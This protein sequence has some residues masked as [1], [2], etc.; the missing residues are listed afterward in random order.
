MKYF[1]NNP[2][3]VFILLFL[4]F[5]F[6]NYGQNEVLAFPTAKG[7]G[8]YATGGRGGIVVHVTNLNDAGPGSLR[9]ALNMT[10][11]RII[12]FDVSGVITIDALLYIDADNSNFTLAGQT[13]PEGGI[14][15]DGG[16]VYFRDVDNYI[17]RYVRFKGG[18]D[19]DGFPNSGDGNGSASFTTGV[20]L[21][22]AI[23]DHCSFGF[24]KTMP[25][26]Y[27]SG[28]DGSDPVHSATVQN[29]LFSETF[30]GAIIGK[31]W[32]N[33]GTIGSMTFRNNMF[34]NSKYRFPNVG[35]FSQDGTNVDVINN[36]AWS[37]TGRLMRCDGNLNLNHIGNSYYYGPL[38]VQNT[39]V[40]LWTNQGF[41]PQIYTSN[42]TIIAGNESSSLFSSVAEMN[43]DNRLSWR[44]FVGS[45]YGDQVPMSFFTDTQFPI[46]GETYDIITDPIELKNYLVSNVGCNAR[47]NAD[48]SVSS[49][50]DVLDESYL[51]NVS[52]NIFVPGLSLDQYIVPSIPSVERPS[53]YYQ[54]NPHIP[55]QW[56]S[57]NVPDGQDHNDIAPS[58]YTWMEEFLNQVDYAVIE[59]VLPESL[60]LTPDQAQLEV[61]D[62]IQLTV[63]F[64]PQNTTNQNGT[65][66]SSNSDIATVDE[67]GLV[68]ALM[69]GDVEITFISEED[70]NISAIAEITVF[71]EALGASAGD[72]Q[73][74]CI[75]D[76]TTLTA[77]GGSSFLWDTGETTASIDVNPSITTTYTVTVFDDQ[78]NSDE[79]SVT[80]TV[81]S[82]PVAEAGEDQTICEGETIIL[83][84]TGGEEYLW[85]NGETTST[86]AVSPTIDTVYNVEVITNNCSSTDSVTIFVNDA[87]DLTVSDDVNI[88]EGNSTVLTV[89]GGDNYLWSTGETT[90]EITVSPLETTSYSVS[91]T[92]LN[93]CSTN[94]QI[95]VTVEPPFTASA[96]EDRNVCQNDTYEVELT[97]SEGDSYLWSTGETTQSIIVSPLSTTTYTVTVNSGSQV[98]SD[99]V[100]VFVDP[101]PN[102]VIVNGA[103]VNIMNGDFVTLSATGANSY[104]WNNGAT[105]PNIAVSPSQTTTYEVRGYINDCYD[106]KLVTVNVIP[107]VE[108]YAGEDV[109]ICLGET[110]TLTATGGDDYE[111]STGESTQSIQV[112]PD[113][114]TEYTVTVFNA[115]D[116][117]EDS[118]IVFVDDNCEDNTVEQ[119]ENPDNSGDFSFDVFPN[120]AANQVNV[121]LSGTVALSRIYLY[122]ITGKLLH[123][124]IIA[125]ENLSVSTT[126]TFDV[127]MLYPGMYYV[128]LVDIK[129]DITKRFIKN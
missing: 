17:M 125:N 39:G 116:F 47:L 77:S 61:Y 25:T 102:V 101:N 99:D 66:S 128:R 18:V 13:A 72:D 115:L 89:N 69:P 33:G 83:T 3:I 109:E 63:N 51:E 45:N 58:G 59:E 68:S 110:V 85:S 86:I 75:G 41:N 114:T 26:W 8:A 28:G 36:L 1:Y 55:E 54:S 81:N 2:Y 91:S 93:G 50:L 76:S 117:D 23:T 22:N 108:A 35:G 74:I 96:G 112:S 7:A 43:A 4:I 11:P 40:N 118:V 113:S 129:Q 119:P 57:E 30:K 27:S 10:V 80:V 20:A 34:Y 14:T 98:D 38:L 126:K 105:Q 73:D 48:G 82:I 5:P 120:P 90:S 104:I 52:N 121:R 16:R 24:G 107:E 70:S 42:N 46:Q 9:E 88:I 19:A 79:D 6:K 124:E 92:G 15:I 111:W 127:S 60:T 103:N 97:A 95:T 100:T 64:A 44:Y 65:W 94:L 21:T 56:F 67:N 78:G 123:S 84:A 37:N 62:T 122:D 29:C 53:D 71:A 31:N 106:E 12:V 32:L 49:N 87:P